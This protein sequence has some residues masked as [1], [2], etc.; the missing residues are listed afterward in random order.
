M[1]GETNVEHL[2][3]PAE[4]ERPDYLLGLGQAGARRLIL[5]DIERLMSVRRPA[6]RQVA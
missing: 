4:G 6:A 3:A 1:S 2:P 5:L